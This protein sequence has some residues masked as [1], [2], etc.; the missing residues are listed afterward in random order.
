MVSSAGGAAAGVAL[1]LGACHRTERGVRGPCGEEGIL[2]PWMQGCGA[3]RTGVAA[4]SDSH[5]CWESLWRAAMSRPGLG[6]PW[7]LLASQRS[8][9]GCTACSVNTRGPC[10]PW[11][12]QKT[13]PRSDLWQPQ[14]VDASCAKSGRRQALFFQKACLCLR[15]TLTMG[16]WWA[17]RSRDEEGDMAITALCLFPPSPSFPPFSPP[18]PPL[19]ACVRLRPFLE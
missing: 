9:Q 8:K 4:V 7:D 1:S 18:R 17:E 5:T 2:L 15:V 6:L 12:Q 11:P 3:G 10:S 14:Q 16:P 13:A 19:T